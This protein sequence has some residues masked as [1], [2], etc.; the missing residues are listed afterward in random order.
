MASSESDLEVRGLN[1]IIVLLLILTACYGVGFIGSQ[2]TLTGVRGWYLTIAKPS[3]TPPGWLFAPV[4]T[5]LYGMMGAAAY[6]VWQSDHP[7]RRR[8]SAF[9]W[10]QLALNGLWSWLFF[11]WQRP[12]W[13]F[14]ELVVLFL[15][16]ALTAATFWRVRP[17]AGKL[18]VPYLAWVAFAGA[19]NLAIYLMNR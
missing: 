11:G 5:V 9:F 14:I 1:P 6:L 13:A 10:V 15:M 4:W 17:L 3:W 12:L 8:A 7:L 2:A 18:L 16:I 19:L